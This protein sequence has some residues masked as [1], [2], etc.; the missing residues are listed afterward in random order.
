MVVFTEYADTAD[1]LLDKFREAGFSAKRYSGRDSHA[2]RDAIRAEFAAGEFQ[3]IVSTDA[4]NEGIDL[5]TAAV[6]VNWDIPW[7]LVR[8]EQRM[9]RI[10]RIG[11]REKVWL[12]NLVATDTREGEAHARLLEN[13]VTAANEL[14]GKV[15]D[16]L[17]LVA[18]AALAEAGIDS[19]QKLLQRTFET[20]GDANPAVQAIRQ[21][22]AERLR[23][24]HEEQ[25]RAS[26]TSRPQSTRR[27][28]WQR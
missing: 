20:D 4:G 2:E 25:R 19:L 1:W 26:P 8:L 3:V 6:L 5:Q 10:H 16:S 7:S 17:R 15:F 13:L 22:T 27:P 12:Y 11:Q 24:I 18:E 14:D 9:G 23:Q 28:R 21:V